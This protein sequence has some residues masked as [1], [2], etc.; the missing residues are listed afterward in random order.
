MTRKLTK[1]FMGRHRMGL[2]QHAIAEA[3]GVTQP[4]ISGW[5]TG[6]VDIPPKR[7]KQIAKLLDLDPATLTDEA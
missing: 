3:I 5:E 2:T 7:R 1:M 6:A 4:R